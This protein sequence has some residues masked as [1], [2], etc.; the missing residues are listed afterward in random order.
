LGDLPFVWVVLAGTENAAGEVVDVQIERVYANRAVAERYLEI[1]DEAL[2]NYEN[3]RD[4]R[5]IE[6]WA[7][8]TGVWDARLG[9]EP[10]EGD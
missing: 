2:R 10:I 3:P 6:E 5:W 7:V 4:L 8:Q 1:V 9:D